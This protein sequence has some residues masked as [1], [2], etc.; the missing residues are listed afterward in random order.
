MLLKITIDVHSLAIS[1]LL[2]YGSYALPVQPSWNYDAQWDTVL[3][4]IVSSPQSSQNS[5]WMSV[6]FLPYKVWNLMYEHWSLSRWFH[7]P[8]C[9]L[10][11]KQEYKDERNKFSDAVFLILALS[12]SESQNGFVILLLT[13]I[14]C[15]L[16]FEWPSHKFR[17][18][19]E[20]Q[21]ICNTLYYMWFMLG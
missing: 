14:Q 18:C 6:G 8:F 11:I 15:V 2:F 20:G 3:Q 7:R 16:L 12:C 4:F 13:Q 19:F 1:G 17:R 21:V 10:I 9:N 5:L